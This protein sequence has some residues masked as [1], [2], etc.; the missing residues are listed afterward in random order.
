MNGMRAVDN[1][2]EPVQVSDSRRMALGTTW[3]QKSSTK[4]QNTANPFSEFFIRALEPQEIVYGLRPSLADWVR[5]KW[6]A[7]VFCLAIV[8]E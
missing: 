8:E 5:F 7:I 6:I 2:M 3:P 4:D 1:L